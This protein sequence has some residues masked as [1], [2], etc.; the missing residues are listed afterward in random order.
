VFAVRRTSS[1]SPSHRPSTRR[2]PRRRS[3]ERRERTAELLERAHRASPAERARC[4]QEVIE[5]NLGVAADVAQRFRG[6]G[7][8]DEDL[9]Q[10][11][12]LGLVKAVR[13]YDPTKASDLLTFAVPTIRGELRRHFRDQGWMVRP[14]R[15]IQELQA[16][17]TAAEGELYQALERAPRPDEI[18]D[19]LEVE[20]GQVVAA[21]AA[22]GCFTPASLDDSGPGED[23]TPVLD[24]FGSVDPG[25]ER[26]EAR[27]ML[28]P[29][30]RALS[31]RERRILHL[32]FC[33]GWNQAQIGEEI[34]VT[35]MQVSRLLQQ[36]L[37]RLR[38][39]LEQRG[40]AEP[41]A[42]D[43]AA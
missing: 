25:F 16:K 22:N 36:I 1:K 37:T 17:V 26:A 27:M 7:I 39:Q 19:H 41:A 31:R 43:R 23:D 8:A 34:G 20:T 42:P 24:R 33:H 21:Q 30:L 6:R 14:P 3:D 18:A 9:R 40:A 13:A 35:Q 15:S 2:S 32:R 5:L 10:V 12:H 28:R 38:D 11:T 4:E 29:L